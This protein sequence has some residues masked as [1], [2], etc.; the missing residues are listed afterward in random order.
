MPSG[1]SRFSFFSNLL[2]RRSL[3][4]ARSWPSAMID[5]ERD[6]AMRSTQRTS[7]RQL[8]FLVRQRGCLL[9]TLRM[10]G[11]GVPAL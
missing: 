6:L 11:T 8:Q 2:T 3:A 10:P 1:V 9:L 5:K 7:C 4:A